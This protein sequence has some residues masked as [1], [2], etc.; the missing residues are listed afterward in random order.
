MKNDYKVRARKFYESVLPFIAEWDGEDV[1]SL[2]RMVYK[3]NEVKHRKVRVASGATRV[4]LICS[5]YVIKMDYGRGREDFGGCEDEYNKYLEACECG[6]EKILCPI[7]KIDK[8]VYVMP[9]A[10]TAKSYYDET[11]M[12]RFFNHLTFAEKFFVNTRISDIHNFNVGSYKRRAVLI[13]Y[14]CG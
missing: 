5:D 1:E 9:K 3:Y 6:C 13:D 8:D 4:V 12:H 11:Y 7:D 2:W 14:A 10:N